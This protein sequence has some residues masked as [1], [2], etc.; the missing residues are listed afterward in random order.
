MLLPAPFSLPS[1]PNACWNSEEVS[2]S[3]SKKVRDSLSM[4]I[5][6]APSPFCCSRSYLMRRDLFLRKSSQAW[7]FL[8]SRSSSATALR[9]ARGPPLR[10]V[11]LLTLSSCLSASPSCFTRR[12]MRDLTSRSA[13]LSV[14]PLR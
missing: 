6:V 10:L 3:P 11:P 9:E 7:A 1:P 2:C 4:N 13:W 12:S 14:K 5:M 8:S